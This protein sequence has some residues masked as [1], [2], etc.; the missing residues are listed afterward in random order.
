M[1]Q[2]AGYQEHPSAEHNTHRQNAN[3]QERTPATCILDATIMYGH[4]KFAFQ[5]VLSL[6][7]MGLCIDMLAS[8][9]GSAEVYLLLVTAIIGFWLPSPRYSVISETVAH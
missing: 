4:L 7:V 2:R 1:L 9:T 8:K 3:R 6:A 5:A